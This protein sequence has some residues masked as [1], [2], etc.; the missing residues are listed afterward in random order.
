MQHVDLSYL[1]RLAG[2]NNQFVNEFID[3]FL[4][5]TPSY[6]QEVRHQ[7]AQKNWP[8]LQA[9]AHRFKTAV[10]YLGLSKLAHIIETIEERA[11]QK[12]NKENLFELVAAMNAI[13]DASVRELKSRC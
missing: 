3:C 7:C 10:R 9:S 6:V 2:G 11:A 4:D 5:T 13:Y 8:G 1:I 12:V